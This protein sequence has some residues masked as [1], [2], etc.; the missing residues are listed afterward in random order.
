MNRPTKEQIEAAI[1][2]IQQRI[3]RGE[4]GAQESFILRA[5]LSTR[6]PAQIMGRMIGYIVAASL[7]VLASGGLVWAAKMAARMVAG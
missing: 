3:E 4:A 5:Y 6:R 2:Y 1:G 7:L